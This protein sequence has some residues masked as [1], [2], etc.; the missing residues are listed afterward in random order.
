MRRFTVMGHSIFRANLKKSFCTL[1]A[2][3]ISNIVGNIFLSS[4]VSEVIRGTASF[5]CKMRLKGTA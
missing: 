1:L 5:P 4:S 2:L 3:L